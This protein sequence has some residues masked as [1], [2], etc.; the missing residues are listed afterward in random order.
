MRINIFTIPIGS[1][2]GLL[3]EM[4]RFMATHKVLQI[5]HHFFQNNSGGYWTFC[6]RYLEKS[7]EPEHFPYGKKKV[8]YK[9]ILNA[10]DFE[11]F[12]KLREVRKIIADEDAVPAYAVFTDAELAEIAKL[13]RIDK[14]RLADIS[15][16][17]RKKIE[18]YGE[19]LLNSIQNERLFNHETDREPDLQD[20]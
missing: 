13:D 8:D 6:I 12:S 11:K 3:D 5:D 18:K 2:P 9:S 7:N 15:G 10:S 17:G 1:H 19:S 14:K 4:N 20:S 16:I